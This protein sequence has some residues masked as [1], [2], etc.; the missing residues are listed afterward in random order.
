MTRW[1]GNLHAFVVLDLGDDQNL[2]ALLTKNLYR[3]IRSH[4]TTRQIPR[5]LLERRSACG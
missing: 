5:E 2:L 3:N 4:S 1:D